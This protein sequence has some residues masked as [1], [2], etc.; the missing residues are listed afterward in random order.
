MWER[1]RRNICRTDDRLA[2]VVPSTFAVVVPMPSSLSPISRLFFILFLNLIYLTIFKCKRN[3][4]RNQEIPNFF[5]NIISTTKNKKVKG[6]RK[7]KKARLLSFLPCHQRAA[8]SSPWAPAQQA[9]TSP[10]SPHPTFPLC[11]SV[12]VQVPEV[13]NVCRPRLLAY[14]KPAMVMTRPTLPLSRN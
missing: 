13:K 7:K 1:G 11:P 10:Q 4:E 6:K 2:V 12:Q 14:F 3:Q 8:H 9:A 5:T